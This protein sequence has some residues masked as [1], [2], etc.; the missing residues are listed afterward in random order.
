MQERYRYVVEFIIAV[1][2]TISFL[3]IAIISLLDP[4]LAFEFV[5]VNPL[6]SWM[7]PITGYAVHIIVNIFFAALAIF[8]A[9]DCWRKYNEYT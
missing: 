8:F 2:F 5:Q 1:F 6:F 3:I 7:N 9:L 4:V